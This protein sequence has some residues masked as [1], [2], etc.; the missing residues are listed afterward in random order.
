MSGDSVSLPTNVIHSDT[1]SRIQQGQTTDTQAKEKLAQKLREATEDEHA[2][3]KNVSE[4][5]RARLQRKRR[6]QE[7]RER[8][9]RQRQEG[10]PDA[11]GRG[12]KI[13]LKV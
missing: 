1:I 6:D 13:D 2:L 10:R 5:E 12:G 3:A 7:S 11:Q 8:R 4:T 9:E